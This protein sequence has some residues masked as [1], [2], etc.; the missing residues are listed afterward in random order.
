MKEF[1]S[2]NVIDECVLDIAEHLIRTEIKFNGVYGIPRGGTLL[3]VMLSHKLNIPFYPLYFS[4]AKLE[5][6]DFIV[7]DDI[8]DTGKTLQGYKIKDENEQGYYVTIH[9]HKDSIVKPDYSVIYKEDKWI[10][11][12]WE[13]EDSNEIQDYFKQEKLDV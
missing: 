9:E 2:W 11:Y 12:P 10:V 4:T 8:A 5:G 7:I 13:T 3:A 6:N 1:I